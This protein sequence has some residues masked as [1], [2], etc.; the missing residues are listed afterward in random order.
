MD[1]LLEWLLMV[2]VLFG[3][4]FAV[5]HRVAICRYMRAEKAYDLDGKRREVA[6]K[7]RIEDAEAE[8]KIINNGRREK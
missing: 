1:F 2:V 5:R 3:I 4:V 7:R 6:L 8:L